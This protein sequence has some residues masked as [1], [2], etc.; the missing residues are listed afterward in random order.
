MASRGKIVATL[1]LSPFLLLAVMLFRAEVYYP[2]PNLDDQCG[3]IHTPIAGQDIVDRFA[4]ALTIK[5]ITLDQQNYD[6]ES[7]VQFAAFLRK[8]KCHPS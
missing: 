6:A 4:E 2:K 1:V 8:S 7:R 5:T 3:Q